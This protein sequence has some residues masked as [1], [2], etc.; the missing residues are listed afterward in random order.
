MLVRSVGAAQCLS[1]SNSTSA[2]KLETTEPTD[3]DHGTFVRSK[4]VNSIY[5]FVLFIFLRTTK[6]SDRESQKCV[7]ICLE[8]WKQRN[9]N[10][11][12]HVPFILFFHYCLIFFMYSFHGF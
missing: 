4:G 9:R 3:H 2:G 6:S 1:L 5:A 11:I 10:K 8:S 7:T 12:I